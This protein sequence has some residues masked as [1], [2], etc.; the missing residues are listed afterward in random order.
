MA[1]PSSGTR[2]LRGPIEDWEIL[3]NKREDEMIRAGK[4]KQLEKLLSSGDQEALNQYFAQVS[5]AGMREARSLNG[6]VARLSE[7]SSK[8]KKQVSDFDKQIRSNAAA[9]IDEANKRAQHELRQECD[10]SALSWV[11]GTSVVLT[12]FIGPAGFLLSVP[13]A[14]V[15]SKDFEIVIPYGITEK[16]L[17][18]YLLLHPDLSRESA[19]KQMLF[20]RSV[21]RV[22]D[23]GGAKEADGPDGAARIKFKGKEISI[24]PITDAQVAQYQQ[25]HPGTTQEKTIREIARSQ[26]QRLSSI[27]KP[28]SFK[29]S[30]TSDPDG[31]TSYSP[32]Y[33]ADAL[34]DYSDPDFSCSP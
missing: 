22:F 5:L 9:A 23:A 2:A 15:F 1:A 6:R 12:P 13:V 34:P 33:S 28:S 4:D 7:E 16:E 18:E 30:D 26:D 19:L 10:N 24:F 17:V 20:D 11:L 32:D 31:A 3:P 27:M 29:G 14:M 21:K 25:D 8:L